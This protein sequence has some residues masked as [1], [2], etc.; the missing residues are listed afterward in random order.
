MHA[1]EGVAIYASLSMFIFFIYSPG[2]LS[3]ALTPCF[4]QVLSEAQHTHTHT[5]TIVRLASCVV[6]LL[7]SS[8]GMCN[9]RTQKAPL[10]TRL[11]VRVLFN[12]LRLPAFF[13]NDPICEYAVRHM[14]KRRPPYWTEEFVKR[15]VFHDQS[16][17]EKQIQAGDQVERFRS[18]YTRFTTRG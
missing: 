3:A 11:R 5:H 1:D 18:V 6:W 8:L 7:V 12:N 10:D 16:T 13:L 2:A 14:H 15:D 4:G 17:C 9:C